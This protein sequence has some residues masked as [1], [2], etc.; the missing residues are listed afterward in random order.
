MYQKTKKYF[1]SDLM[2]NFFGRT[3]KSDAGSTKATKTNVL[4]KKNPSYHR[5]IIQQRNEKNTRKTCRK[6]FC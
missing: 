2:D 4:R 6:A 3:T 1:F 5:K